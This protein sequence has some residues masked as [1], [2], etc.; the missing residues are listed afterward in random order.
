VPK[1]SSMVL[2]SD[3]NLG[4]SADQAQTQPVWWTGTNG[5]AA[6]QLH[7]VHVLAPQRF[8]HLHTGWPVSFTSD[9]GPH[10]GF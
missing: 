5:A 8:R 6:T 9:A 10:L 7:A 3:R 1:F 2:G 4:I